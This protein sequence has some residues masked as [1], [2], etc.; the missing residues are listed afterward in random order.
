MASIGPPAVSIGNGQRAAVQAAARSRELAA[1]DREVRAHERA[2]QAAGGAHAG[3]ISY[4]YRR[5]SGGRRYAVGGEVALD[6]SREGSPGE[7]LAKMQQVRDAALAPTTPSAADRRIAATAA[8][9]A[10]EARA[11]LAR[12]D[13]ALVQRDRPGGAAA[14]GGPTGRYA[15]V[16]AMTGGELMRLGG[17][18]DLSA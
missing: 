10:N 13:A 16:A 7:T 6:L 14:G 8:A 18:L 11:E 15:E 2:H 12:G 1:R 3:A 4:D 17:R 9:R 5:G